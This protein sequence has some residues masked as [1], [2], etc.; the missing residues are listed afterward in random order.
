MPVGPYLLLEY[1][2]SYDYSKGDQVCRYPDQAVLR[3]SLEAPPCACREHTHTHTHVKVH[4]SKIHKVEQ[5]QT[6]SKSAC[7]PAIRTRE[8]QTGQQMV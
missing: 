6:G 7:K 2:D 8:R 3:R 4:D 5:K 1:K